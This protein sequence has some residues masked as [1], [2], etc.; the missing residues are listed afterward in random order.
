MNSDKII[1]FKNDT[2]GEIRGFIDEKTGEPWF[3]AGK[4]CDCLK[5]KNSSDALKNIKEK[6]LKFGDKLDGV[7]IIYPI[8]IDRLG[9]KQRTAAINE[10]LLYELIFQSRTEK[11]FVF[12]QWVFKEVLPSLRKHGEYRMTGKLIRRSLTDSVQDSGENERMHGH[13]ISNYTR[14][15]NKS[16]GLPNTVDRSSL[17]DEMLERVAR[18]EDTV[19]CLINEGKCYT[20]IKNF[21][22]ASSLQGAG[23]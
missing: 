21:I 7:A 13:G 11:A 20:E 9:R 22:E 23:K 18:R 8:I 4:V 15:I 5:I 17:S 6:H 10:S 14:L 2:I 1:S 3:F 12:Q 19:R 16:L